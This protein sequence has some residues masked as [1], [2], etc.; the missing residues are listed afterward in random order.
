LREADS[1]REGQPPMR[2]IV[3]SDALPFEEQIR[4]IRLRSEVISWMTAVV[5]DNPVEY[6]FRINDEES[7]PV[8][9]TFYRSY[10]IYYTEIGSI[11]VPLWISRVT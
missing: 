9:V 10:V 2:R 1:G 8:Y 3:L 7:D 5:V 6:S 11:V 4:R